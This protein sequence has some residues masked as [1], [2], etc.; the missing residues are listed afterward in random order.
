MTNTKEN[1]P[2]SRNQA[3]NEELFIA[4]CK[5]AEDRE[6]VMEKMK[7]SIS[8]FQKYYK[9]NRNLGK[10]PELDGRIVIDEKK[11]DELK[12]YFSK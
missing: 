6:E 10:I 4:T 3:I 11:I 9:K 12:Q 1:K 5:K 2:R 8:T 7:I